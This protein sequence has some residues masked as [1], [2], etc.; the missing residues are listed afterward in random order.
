MLLPIR[1]AK[2]VARLTAE[3]VSFQRLRACSAAV[4]WGVRLAGCLHSTNTAGPQICLSVCLSSCR[5]RCRCWWVCMAA[6]PEIRAWRHAIAASDSS[7]S[8][9]KK[10][11]TGSSIM[12]SA[13]FCRL[14]DTLSDG[15]PI[16]I[17]KHS[18]SES[19]YLLPTCLLDA[20]LLDC[21]LSVERSPVRCTDSCSFD[22]RAHAYWT[23]SQP[24]LDI[25][26]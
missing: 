24:C 11:S 4:Q 19:T 18:V 3:M 15:R 14:G 17:R 8:P 2:T 21:L 13:A 9:D 5:C 22:L 26:A 25:H 10:Q 6:E 12:S 20:L 1:P 7:L 16:F 23:R